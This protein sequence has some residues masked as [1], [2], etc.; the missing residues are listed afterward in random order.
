MPGSA[1]VRDRDAVVAASRAAWNASEPQHRAAPAWQRLV[2]GFATADFSCLD[3]VDREVLGA[4]GVAG[5]DVG[6]L[7]CNNGR[8]ILS[9]ARLGA[10]RAV[11]FDQAGAFIA[12]ARE[13]AAI[14][15]SPCEFVET[16]VY[17]IG[18][19]FDAAFDV[20]V[21]TIG[22][23]GWMPELGRFVDIA[24]RLLR[25]GGILY[26]HEQHPI[27][28]VF[29]PWGPTPFEPVQS[30]F[31][32]EPFVETKAIVYDDA[33]PIGVADYYWFVHPLADVLTA[34]LAAGF[35]IER[36]SEYPDNISSDVYAIY[37]RPD[38]ALPQSYAL[39][40]RKR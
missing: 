19:E 28:N 26:V 20:V 15:G 1:E 33:V 7:C 10:R 22:V 9:I 36:Y 13:L 27:M 3:A 17:A 11:G 2:E 40:C 38:R 18:P 8:E 14:A 23:F 31:R 4:I 24:A 39:V 25:P 32:P 16:D 21:V 6:Q 12:Q 30:Y 5:R 34:C 29:E 35:A 37:D